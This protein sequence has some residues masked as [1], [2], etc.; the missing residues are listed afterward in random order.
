M[1]PA[2][3]NGKNAERKRARRERGS[4]CLYPNQNI[5]QVI[6]VLAAVI[7]VINFQ[8]PCTG[9][10]TKS[11]LQKQVSRELKGKRALAIRFLFSPALER[12]TCRGTK[13]A[14]PP[15]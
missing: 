13:G 6:I 7:A 8:K 1:I 3:K 2:A 10:K 4:W 11:R 5:S 14:T 9:P 12:V 15:R